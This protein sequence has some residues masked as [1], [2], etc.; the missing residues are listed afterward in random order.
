[1]RYLTVFAAVL[2]VSM[3]PGCMY[4]AGYG[5]YPN[6]YYGPGVVPQQPMNGYPGVPNYPTYVAPGGNGAPYTPGSSPSGNGPTP[7]FS[8]TSPDPSNGSSPSTYGGGSSG[9]GN[10]NEPLFN[11]ESPTGRP[12]V[13]PPGDDGA[14]SR[15]GSGTSQ[16]PALTPTTS[17]KD[18][19]DITPFTQKESRRS[20]RPAVD[21][22]ESLVEIDDQFQR[23][24]LQ[25]SA[26]DDNDG[27]FA[28]PVAKS[29]T[30]SRLYAH[31][32]EFTWVRGVVEYDKPTKTWAIL[33]DESPPASDSLGGFLILADDS[34][35]QRLRTGDKVQ[36][37][38]TLDDSVEDSRKKP[39]YRMSGFKRLSS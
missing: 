29:G 35:L 22:E 26:T 11:P 34:S 16:R 1:M 37:Y 17:A 32:P 6:G 18:S 10:N 39:V 33:Y 20:R 9:N 36:I 38:G 2:Y 4:H 8:P 25:T 13:P 5:G 14:D 19:G 21:Q 3:A 7:I 24:V 23:P 12:P 28:D 15:G 31:D 27:A 30:A